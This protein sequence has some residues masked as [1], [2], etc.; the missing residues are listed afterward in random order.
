MKFIGLLAIISLVVAGP[1]FSQ[2]LYVS[3]EPASNTA[4]HSVGIRLENQGYFI[5]GYKNR[6]IVEVMY[7]ASKNLMLHSSIYQS[8]YYQNS[9]RFEGVSAYAKYRFFSVDSVQSHFRGALFVK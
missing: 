2:E 4:T 8:N 1:V 5:P 6:G 3:T 9:Q 7:G